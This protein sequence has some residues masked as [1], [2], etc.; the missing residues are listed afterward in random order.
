MMIFEFQMIFQGIVITVVDGAEDQTKE[1]AL[2]KTTA[3]L[4]SS[5]AG[6]FSAGGGGGQTYTCSQCGFQTFTLDRVQ[7]H[8]RFCHPNEGRSQTP[9][10]RKSARRSELTA[11]QAEREKQRQFTSYKTPDGKKMFSCR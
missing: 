2:S 9:P 8:F 11:F 7:E 4:K 3:G 5:Q 1:G 10:L 6:N